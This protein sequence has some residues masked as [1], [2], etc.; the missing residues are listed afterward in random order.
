MRE[1][2]WGLT[3]R[4][5]TADQSIADITPRH[6]KLLQSR[7]LKFCITNEVLLLLLLL[8]FFFPPPP[9]PSPPLIIHVYQHC[10]YFEG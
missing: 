3:L 6:V 8:G 2:Q 5:P 10:L 9:P 4:H 1:C 7:V